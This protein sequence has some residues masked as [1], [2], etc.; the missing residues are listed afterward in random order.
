MKTVICDICEKPIDERSTQY[1]LKKRF[2]SVFGD[3]QPFHRKDICL[4]CMNRIIRSIEEQEN[5]NE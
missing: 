4:K 1:I 5:K 2:F 3:P